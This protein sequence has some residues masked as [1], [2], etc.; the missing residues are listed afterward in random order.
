MEI[1][2]KVKARHTGLLTPSQIRALRQRLNLT[3][4]EICKLLQTGMKTWTRWETGRER[5]FRSTNVLLC[6]L[7]DGKIDVAYLRALAELRRERSLE[8]K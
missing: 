3:Q 7:N 8:R 6:A 2:D 1:L 5:P 4:K